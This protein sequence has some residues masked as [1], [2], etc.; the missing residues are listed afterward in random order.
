MKRTNKNTLPKK[1]KKAKGK[2]VELDSPPP[3]PTAPTASALPTDFVEV[4][5]GIKTKLRAPNRMPYIL[6]ELKKHYDV[7]ADAM[8]I[9]GA[10]VE[11]IITAITWHAKLT[12]T[13]KK[14]SF[15]QMKQDM[16]A[17]GGFSAA[18]VKNKNSCIIA[19]LSSSW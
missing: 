12:S 10:S 3:A 11:N 5:M 14:V 16:E 18:D 8:E 2:Q 4:L 19:F 1:S 15:N 9:D 6:S 17:S 13:S 7:S